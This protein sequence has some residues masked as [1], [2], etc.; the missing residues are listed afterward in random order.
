MPNTIERMC[1]NASATR[2]L[3]RTLGSVVDA[4]QVLLIRGGLGAGK[5]TFVQGLAEGL[6][7]TDEAT[8]PTFN[9]VHVYAGGRLPLVHLDLYRLGSEGE[10]LESGYASHFESGAVIA[11]E[12]PERLGALTP[13]HHIAVCIEPIGKSGRR[14]TL[15]AIGGQVLPHAVWPAQ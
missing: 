3:G 1:P 5:T 7:C 9:L 13:T 14:I 6:G 8:S 10:V 4:K 15:E 2:E 11:I 12:W